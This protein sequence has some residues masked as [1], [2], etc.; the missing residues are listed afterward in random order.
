MTEAVFQ[1]SYADWKLIRTRKC[2]QIVFEVPLEAADAAYQVVGGMP[3]SGEE[4]WFAIA[5]LKADKKHKA[6][7]AQAPNR[8]VQRA[9]ILCSEEQFQ[10][11]LRTSWPAEWNTAAEDTGSDDDTAAIVLRGLCAIKSR[12]ELSTNDEA[13]SRFEAVT[14]RYEAWRRGLE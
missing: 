13:S 12:K 11:F 6:K 7:T 2:V 10:T 1:A 4:A 14:T 9:G 5:R 3:N 8:L